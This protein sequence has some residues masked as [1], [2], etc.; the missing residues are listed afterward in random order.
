MILCWRA[1][2][3]GEHDQQNV[4]VEAGVLLILLASCMPV[5]PACHGRAGPRRSTPS[6]GL[7]SVAGPALPCRGDRAHIQPQPLHC[8]TSTCGRCRCRRRSAGACPAAGRPVRVVLCQTLAGRGRLIHSVLPWL[9]PVWM[10]KSPSI[11]W[12]SWRAM[13]RPSRPPCR[14][15]ARK[16]WLSTAAL[17]S[18]SRFRPPADGRCPDGDAQSRTLGRPVDRR[19]QQHSPSSVCLK[20]FSNR[21]SRVCRR[22]VGSPV[23]TCGNCGWIKLISLDL[24]LLGLGAEDAQAVPRQGI[25]VELHLVQFDLAGPSLEISRISLIRLSSSLP[26]L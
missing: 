22:R 17:S 3:A 13:I 9:A 16:S 25:E 14:V 23:T 4:V 5:I 26:E 18:A 6:G 20:A 11:S 8:C 15:A 1:A 10:P 2:H 7:W 19:D 24:L 21:F 12:T